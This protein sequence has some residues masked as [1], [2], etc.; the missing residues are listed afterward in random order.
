MLECP[1]GTMR[2]RLLEMIRSF[3]AKRLSPERHTALRNAHGEFYLHWCERLGY[4]WHRL[5]RETE[6]L[7]A[8]LEF[9][10]ETSA[11]ERALRL[12][13]PVRVL[14]ELRGGAD[15]GLLLLRRA[16]ALPG[17]APEMRC[18]GLLEAGSLLLTI[19]GERDEARGYLDEALALSK[20]NPTLEAAVLRAQIHLEWVRFG[21]SPEAQTRLEHALTLARQTGAQ[22]TQAS[23]LNLRGILAARRD[24]DFATAESAYSQAQDL[25]EALGDMLHANYTLFNRANAALEAGN[26]L[27]ALEHYGRCRRVCQ[28]LGDTMLEVDVANSTGALLV[29]LGRWEEAEAHFAAAIHQAWQLGY[30]YMLGHALWNLAEVRAQQDHATDAVQLL[31]FAEHFWTTNFAALTDDDKGY[32]ERIRQLCAAQI[33]APQTHLLWGQGSA[34]PLREAVFLALRSSPLAVPQASDARSR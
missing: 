22:E 5:S 33:G 19:A 15:Y 25:F 3:V 7:Q 31:G 8:A 10:V 21:E 18:A 26:A 17:A 1:D 12:L 30:R 13:K 11:T 34:L 24:Q 4:Q 32:L 16:L 29:S 28:T 23:L 2:F 6:N 14:W 27:I 9:A 20:H